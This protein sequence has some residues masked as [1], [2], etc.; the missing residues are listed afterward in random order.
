MDAYIEYS[1]QSGE[2]DYDVY[3]GTKLSLPPVKNIR[4]GVNYT[5]M[6]SITSPPD[7]YYNGGWECET[8]IEFY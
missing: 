5:V 2:V 1:W 7:Q 3:S 8:D 6:V 4:Y